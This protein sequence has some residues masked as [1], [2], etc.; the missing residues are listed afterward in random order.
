[1]LLT[2]GAY[3]P[4]PLY[5]GYQQL[6]GFNDLMLTL[7]YAAFALLSAPA[8]LIFGS[9][10]DSYGA[11]PVLRI[12]VILS[13][14]GSLCFLLAAG[15]GW[16][17]AGRIAQGIALGAVTAAATALIV[18]GSATTG[19]HRGSLVASVAFV[20][21]TAAGPVAAGALAALAPGPYAL[22]YVVHLVLL[23]Y[24]WVRVQKLPTATTS[25]SR[26]RPTWPS[27]PPGIRSV[28]ATAAATGFLA[29]TAAGIFLAL[30]PSLLLRYLPDQHSASAGSPHVP[31]SPPMS[32]AFGQ[33]ALT[34]GTDA[35]L[36][37]LAAATVAVVLVCSIL[38]QLLS[39]RLPA[40]TA[41]TTGAAILVVA[42]ALL[43]LTGMSASLA[44]F[45]LASVAAGIGHG[46][47]YR[48]AAAR[49]DAVA[50]PQRRGSV[51]AALYLAFYLGTGI[52][53]IA[54]G[55]ITLWYPLGDAVSWLAWAGTGLGIATLIFTR[56]RRRPTG[57]RVVARLWNRGHHLGRAASR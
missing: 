24:G 18:E 3:I 26:W 5:R 31:G 56:A 25:A 33:L 2:A 42:L 4:S 39:A 44:M 48:G 41:Q 13:G 6:F 40:S 38:T 27:I 11:R 53:T 23:V 22:P 9:S 1:M 10:H 47:A 45:V 19:R 17:L 32:H 21:G 57:A 35:V 8:L 29:W 55:A 43:A 46:F 51:T 15:P 14:V 34:H 52:P 36:P 28:F 30:G 16:L 20:A 37:M 7:I 49:V 50:P 54:V 12:S